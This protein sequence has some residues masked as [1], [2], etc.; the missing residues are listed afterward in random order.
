MNLDFIF[1]SLL[2]TRDKVTSILDATSKDQ[3]CIIPEGFNNNLIWNA[4]HILVSQQLLTYGL[5]GLQLPSPKPFIENYRKGTVASQEVTD[6]D[7]VYIKNYLVSMTQFM[8][9][10]YKTGLFKE[11]SK[12]ETSFGITLNNIEESIQFNMIH[13]GWH[14]GY[15]LAQKKKL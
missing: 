3:A 10:D 11:F 6:E 15:M 7:Y 12:Y 8:I 2:E 14:L 13:E 4:G 1:E 5:A 9:D